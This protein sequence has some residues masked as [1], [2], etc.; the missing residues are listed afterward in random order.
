MGY[1]KHHAIVVTCHSRLLLRN[2][3]KKAKSL[4]RCV[5]YVSPPTVNGYQSFIVFP[6]G[7][8][9]GWEESDEGD[10]GREKL[11]TYLRSCNYQDGSCPFD[12]VEI[13]FGD[14]HL[15]TKVLADS[16]EMQRRGVADS[17]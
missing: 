2:A 14:D 6:D 3:W 8:K 4:C 16:D 12:W 13:Q 17:R 5:S 10:A 9:E 15:E 1:T 7:S 11:K